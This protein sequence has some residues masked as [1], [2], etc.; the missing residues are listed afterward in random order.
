MGASAN[1]RAPR[2]VSFQNYAP[3][4]ASARLDETLEQFHDQQRA[5]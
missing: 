1:F 5:H 4:G 2:S 3:P